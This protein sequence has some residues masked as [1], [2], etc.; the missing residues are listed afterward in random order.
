MNLVL[1]MKNNPIPPSPSSYHVD[2]LVNSQVFWSA[3][4]RKTR[5][6][7]HTGAGMREN[8]YGPASGGRV[9]GCTTVPGPMYGFTT[10]WTGDWIWTTNFGLW[11]VGATVYNKHTKTY[12]ILQGRHCERCV[13]GQKNKGRPFRKNMEGLNNKTN[14]Q[15]PCPIL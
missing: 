10:G 5:G 6:L 8:A 9:T 7:F 15:R 1:L 14:Q 12:I 4:V 11:P 3:C 2:K 13:W